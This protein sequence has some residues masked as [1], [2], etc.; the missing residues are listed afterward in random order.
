MLALVFLLLAPPE[1]REAYQRG[2]SLIGQGRAAEALPHFQRAAGLD[3]ANA[4]Y[5]KAVGV[6]FASME[7]LHDSIE[8]FSKACK[9]APGLEDACYYLGRNL[10]ATDRYREAL[11]PLA[12]ALRVDPVKG[13]AETAM[14]QC[15]EALGEERAAE[16]GFRAALARRDAAQ[17]QASIGYG[18]FLI[19]QGRA[20]EAVR[21][22]EAAQQPESAE[23]RYV[24]GLAYSQSGRIR[25]AVAALERAVALQPGHEAAGLLLAKLTVRLTP[26]PQ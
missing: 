8:P 1:A 12:T 15:R 9:L 26:P 5:W 4:Q 2:S 20:P 7:L 10:Y 14:A 3:P 25:E 18:R 24:L 6:A 23:S 17:Q 16:A 19:R 21:L 13:R 11:T 22:L